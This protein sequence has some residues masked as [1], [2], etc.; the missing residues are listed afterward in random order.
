MKAGYRRPDDTARVTGAPDV[1]NPLPAGNVLAAA[2]VNHGADVA[3]FLRLA[4]FDR[5]RYE[6]GNSGLGEVPE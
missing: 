1:Q 4:G 3:D 2:R 5:L 6:A